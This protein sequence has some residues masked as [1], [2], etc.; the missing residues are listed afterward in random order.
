[1]STL[2][3]LLDLAFQAAGA[4]PAS[5]SPI[6]LAHGNFWEYRESY[7]E[8]H[9]AV[10]AIDETTT[11][12]EMHRGRRGYY[13]AQQGGA[14]PASG[15]VEEVEGGI[16][17]LPW[18]GE[19]YLP[20]PLLPGRVGAGSSAD[21]GGWRVEAEEEVTVP[22]GTFK[23]FRCSI[24][25]WSNVSLLWI[26]PGVGVVKEAQGS[27]GRRPEIERVLLRWRRGG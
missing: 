7:A 17:L 14:D 4:A 8:R 5:L 2:V 22:A 1:V 18:T 27:P 11:R 15:P 26:A 12:F 20:V 3:V 9:G 10:D 13:V 6:P 21:H 16:R 25:T 19:D 23:A 24:R